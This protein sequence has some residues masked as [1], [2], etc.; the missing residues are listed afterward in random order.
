[1]LDAESRQA[2]FQ[3]NN[4]QNLQ[5]MSALLN[6]SD[7]V[8]REY[9]NK[10]QSEAALKEL[11]WT[12]DSLS[13]ILLIYLKTIGFP[14]EDKFGVTIIN[15]T[16]L[17]A[18]PVF[19]KLMRRR[20]ILVNVHLDSVFTRLFYQTG[21]NEC[22]LKPEQAVALMLE[23]LDFQQEQAA[24]YYSLFGKHLYGN[25]QISNSLANNI[26]KDLGLI[27]LEDELVKIKSAIPVQ[28]DGFVFSIFL[29]QQRAPNEPK[30]YVD[31]FLDANTLIIENISPD[32]P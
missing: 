2:R 15:D 9:Y 7:V 32:S 24:H 27:S 23:R 21:V 29:V 3:A 20:P 16:I 26:R 18:K 31:E 11:R 12:S 19:Y 4:R 8:Y 28:P 13:K 30:K 22:N 5:F 10:G 17:L 6:K 14:S 25:A 1:M